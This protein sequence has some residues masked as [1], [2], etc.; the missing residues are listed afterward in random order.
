MK[1]VLCDFCKKDISLTGNSVDWRIRLDNQEVPCYD[2]PV[3]DALI[4][5]SLSRG[6][7]FCGVACLKNFI[8][9][10]L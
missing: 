6:Y 3:T 8:N 5:P 7:D 10:E 1:K 9:H 4:Y 2:G